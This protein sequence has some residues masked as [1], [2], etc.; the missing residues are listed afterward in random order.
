MNNVKTYAIFGVKRGVGV[1]T[2]SMNLANY[3]VS[4]GFGKKVSLVVNDKDVFVEIQSLNPQYNVL[5]LNE[6][7]EFPSET[8][9]I[10]FSLTHLDDNAKMYLESIPN[11]RK[12]LLLEPQKNQVEK[13]NEMLKD[14]LFDGTS[15]IVNQFLTNRKTQIDVYNR[16]L[17]GFC[18]LKNRQVYEYVLQGLNLFD[19]KTNLAGRDQANREFRKAF[20]E[21]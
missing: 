20:N 4:L 2:M 17:Q 9:H 16:S 10:I 6:D 13:L 7:T 19:S 12:Y 11:I 18:Y 14:E 3:F 8:S 15:F 1:T 5:M 21:M